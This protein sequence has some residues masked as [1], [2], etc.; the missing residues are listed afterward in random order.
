MSSFTS[1]QFYGWKRWL[2]LYLRLALLGP[3][4]SDLMVQVDVRLGVQHPED[5]A[6]L[7]AG[8]DIEGLIS[9]RPGSVL[10]VVAFLGLRMD[11]T[12]G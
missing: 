11:S 12:P 6:E 7:G 2:Y 9:E 3:F 10:C 5:G 1:V 4:L 8:L